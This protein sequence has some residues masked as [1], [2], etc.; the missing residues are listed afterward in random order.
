MFCWVRGP[1]RSNSSPVEQVQLTPRSWF[2]VQRLK[3]KTEN[4]NFKKPCLR[5]MTDSR[6]GARNV[7]DEIR[8]SFSAGKEKVL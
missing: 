1:P 2:L 3:K 7:Q 5:E 8:T 6:T 4:F